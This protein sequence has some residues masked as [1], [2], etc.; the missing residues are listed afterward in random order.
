MSETRTKI[1]CSA[2]CGRTDVMIDGKLPPDWDQ[3]PLTGRYR[4]TTCTRELAA[5][6]TVPGTEGY[7]P[8]PLPKDSI[9]ALKPLPHREPLK[10]KPQ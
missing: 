7:T 5:V 6:S 9:G 1:G 10:E 2:G 4:C 8:D 3:L